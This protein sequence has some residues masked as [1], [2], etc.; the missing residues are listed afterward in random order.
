MAPPGVTPEV[1][2]AIPP[3]AAAEAWPTTPPPPARA[4]ARRRPGCLRTG[5]LAA[6]IPLI[7]I[8][9]FA[10]WFV[11]ARTQALVKIGL[12]TPPEQRL[13]GGRPNLEAEQ[14]LKA[15][16]LSAGFGDSGLKVAV[17]PVKGKGYNLA[18]AVMDTSQGFRRTGSGD[19]LLDCLEHLGT[20]D[21]AQRYAVGRVAAH[22]YD[23]TGTKILSLTAA[24]EDI[25]AFSDGR[26]SRADFLR[27][28]EGALDWQTMM[29]G[30]P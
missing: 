20:G 26:M 21:A 28:V 7:L 23:A 14:A 25:R 1:F 22:F 19:L 29:G 12:R 16:L 27:S 2:P 15:E 30:S 6:G 13:L 18:V 17:L 10:A 3:Q 4:T 11:A 8:L 9:L 5:C 24:S